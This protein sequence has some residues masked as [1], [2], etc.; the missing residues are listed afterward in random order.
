M[1]VTV[2]SG[3]VGGAKLVLGLSKILRSGEL[4][5]IGNTGDDFELFG[6]HISPDLDIVMYTL[7]GI[8]DQNRSWG[9]EG[10][11]FNF[12]EFLG[13]RYDREK[14]FGLGDK[15]MATHVY[16]TELL[17]K[18][19]KLS[20]VTEVLCSGLG[21]TGIKLIPM[22]DDRV[23]TM[24]KTPDG[25]FIH[26]QEYFVRRECRDV[27]S[28]VKYSG[29]R[30]ARSAEGI[31]K[32][33]RDSDIAVICPS[34]PIASIGPILSIREI[35]EALK[36]TR[37]PVVAVSPIIRGAP[38]KGPAD[39]FMK[40]LGLEVSATGVAKYYRGLIGYLVIDENDAQLEEEIRSMGIIPIVTN[41]VMSTLEDK[42]RL[43]ETILKVGSV[44]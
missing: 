17:R 6:L 23:E 38:L 33:I 35:R 39:K 30:R 41:T 26:F 22:T 16:R 44:S 29:S 15:D 9:I 34:N 12:L 10:D 4:V 32:S 40:S 18:G 37:I 2:L 25:A 20:Q 27:I 43:S 42:I 36:R 11:T 21:L 7:A 24:V 8:V 13:K 14:W 3:G 1:Q 31:L 5:V 28:G 19:Y